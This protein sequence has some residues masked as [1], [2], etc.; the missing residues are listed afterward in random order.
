MK[1]QIPGSNVAFVMILVHI[2]RQAAIYTQ[3]GVD[4]TTGMG[5]RPLKRIIQNLLR[6]GLSV[7]TSHCD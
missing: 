1:L 2:P 5:H 7:T 6:M 4:T 3:Y